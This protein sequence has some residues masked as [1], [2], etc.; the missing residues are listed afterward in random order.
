MSVETGQLI[1]LMLAFIKR[2]IDVHPLDG[3]RFI[4]NELKVSVSPKDF[5]SKH[6]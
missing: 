6:H 1:G 3:Y 2:V 4:T 5:F